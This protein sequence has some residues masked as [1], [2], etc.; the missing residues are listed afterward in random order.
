MFAGKVKAALQMISNEEKGGLLIPD[1]PVED[2]GENVLDILKR[3]HPDNNRW[4]K[5]L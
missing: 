1:Q 4:Y 2:G 5:R 3:K